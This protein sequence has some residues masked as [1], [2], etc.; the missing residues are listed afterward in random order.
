L[1]A[2]LFIIGYGEQAETLLSKFKWGLGFIRL[3]QERLD[4][5][6]KARNSSE[7]VELQRKFM[8]QR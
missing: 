1:A 3:N 8:P 5:Y 7:I 6:A 4:A 2:A